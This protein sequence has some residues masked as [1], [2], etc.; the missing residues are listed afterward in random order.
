M[1]VPT[2][3]VGYTA[4]MSRREDHEVHKDMW[5]HWAQKEHCKVFIAVSSFQSSLYS[6][7][8]PV[9]LQFCVT[10]NS[11]V[12]CILS[13]YSSVWSV[14]LHFYMTCHSTVLYDRLLYSSVWSVIL[15]F[16]MTCHSTVLYDLSFHNSVWSVTLHFY[17][18]CHSTVL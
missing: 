7:I 15:R 10:C 2:S 6:S 3:E 11:T 9:T 1:G 12:L 16:Y 5:W 4:A 8:W 13:L 17:T 14:T 18:T